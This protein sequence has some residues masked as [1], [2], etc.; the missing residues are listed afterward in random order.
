M[1]RLFWE[2]LVHCL[3]LGAVLFDVQPSS[4]AVRSMN[5]NAPSEPTAGQPEPSIS[6]STTPGVMASR[7]E[8]YNELRYI[9]SCVTIWS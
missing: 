6:R 7:R 5:Q 4:A 9:T 3:A 2:P 8:G 1:R